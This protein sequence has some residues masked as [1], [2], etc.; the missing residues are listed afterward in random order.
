MKAPE[1]ENGVGK[2]EREDNMRV[3]ALQYR[4]RKTEED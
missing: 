3:L 1:N 4:K 2:R